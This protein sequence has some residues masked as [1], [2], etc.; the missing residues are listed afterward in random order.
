MTRTPL[1]PR[2][3]LDRS[4][5]EDDLLTTIT[6]ALT[7]FGWTWCHWRRSDKALLMGSPGVPDII[8][9]RRGRVKFIELKAEKGELT[10]EQWAWLH[11]TEPKS[12]HVSWHVYRPSDVDRALKELA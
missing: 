2:Q 11:A 1:T 8:A 12:W 5:S 4:V 7:W 3:Q 10:P 6:E 9:A